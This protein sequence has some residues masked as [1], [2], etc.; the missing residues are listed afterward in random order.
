[1]KCAVLRERHPGETRVAASP[2]MVKRLKNQ[3]VEVAIEAGAGESAGWTDDTFREAGAIVSAD[4]ADVLAGADVVFKVGQPVA[5]G[6]VDELALI[7]EGCVIVGLINPL[8]DREQYAGYAARRLT[9]L[10]MELIP[11][12]SRASR[13][14]P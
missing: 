5:T 1:M 14:T 6:D 2:D 7:P 13:W 8:V 12:I 4:A 9:V 3:G 10:A 11:R